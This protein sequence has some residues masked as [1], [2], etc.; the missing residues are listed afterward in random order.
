[1][2]QMMRIAPVFV[3]LGLSLSLCIA[4]SDSGGGNGNTA[5]SSNSGT[6]GSGN[7]GTAGSGGGSSAGSGSSMAGASNSSTGT[8]SSGLPGDKVLGTLTD[9]ESAA[10]CKKISDSFADGT[11]VAKSVEDFTCRFSSILSALFMTPATDAALQAQCK[12]M[13]DTCIAGPST[14]TE[15][16]K[17]PDATCTATVAEYD[18]CVNDQLKALSQLGNILPTCD[19]ITLASASTLLTGSGT[20]TPASCQTVETKCPSAPTPPGLDS[21]MDPNP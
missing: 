16:C 8:F 19:K 2:L 4:C 17:K 12:S 18:A 11:T 15:T 7:P 5:G 3:S 14:S 9:D 10:L 20:E 1:M 6:A 21:G 13:Y